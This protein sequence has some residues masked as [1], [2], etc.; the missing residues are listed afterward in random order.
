MG[1]V[2]RQGI[3]QTI[4]TY[5]GVVIGMVNV[6]FIYPAMLAREEIGVLSWVRE[7]A[8][9]LSLFVFLG[10]TEL[11]V[12]Y[13]PHFRNEEKKHHGFLFLLLVIV[14][15][16]CLLLAG[17]WLGWRD[18]ILAF[19]ARKEDPTLYLA[20]VRY[21]LPFTVLIAYGNLFTVYASNFHRIVVPS[22]FNEFFP[23]LGL[24]LLAAA[25][26]FGWITLEHIFWGML[27]VHAAMVIAHMLYVRHLGQLHLRP[28]FSRLDRPLLRDMASFSLYGLLGSLGSRFSS[29]FISI[30]MVGT[31][32]NLTNSGIFYIAYLISN[33]ID[34]P[35]K[36]ISRIASPLIADKWN[37]GRREEILEIY[38]KSALNQLIV[39]LGLLLAIWVGI[40][41]L[42]SIMPN[43]HLYESGKVVILV[44]GLARVVDMAT[45]VNSEIISFSRYYRWNFF[46][47]LF[48]AVV[49][50]S[51]N[52]L[53]IPR[54]EILGAA[55]ALLLSMVLFNAAKYVVLYWKLD[56]QPF[57]RNTLWCVLV[58][59]AIASP[60]SF[61]S[62]PTGLTLIDL[63]LKSGG[64]AILY[65]AAVLYLQLSPDLN[66]LAAQ[67]W[68]KGKSWRSRNG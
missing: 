36:A 8:A 21:I 44:L 38:Q 13:F 29:E 16:G 57:T 66:E 39:G 51:A 58:A 55:L 30:F 35:R 11:I 61:L 40:D 50:V 7:T 27:L 25:Y 65:A 26:W 31:L 22:I 42:F 4:V 62:G 59:I 20:Y 43:G 47:I 54:Y 17:L 32:S 18:E 48:M 63:A 53:L 12:R 52:V 23:K 10:S 19:F 33:V 34:V 67:A 2:K 68:E 24:P 3:K 45:G 1:V 6:L 49:H 14:T 28:D 9:M 41:E 60:F 46:L 15:A 64:F 56:M 37:N 5:A